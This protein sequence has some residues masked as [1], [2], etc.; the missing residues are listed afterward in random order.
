M[1]DFCDTRPLRRDEGASLMTAFAAL[2]SAFGRLLEAERDLGGYTGQDPAVVAWIRL[3][4]RRAGTCST[5][6]RMFAPM[7]SARMTR[8]R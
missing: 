6:S 2:V 5:R 8:R 3:P 7:R 1:T 4:R